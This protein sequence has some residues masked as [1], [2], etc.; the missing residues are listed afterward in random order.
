[1]KKERKRAGLS[2]LTRSS[3]FS[4]SLLPLASKHRERKEGDSSLG[5]G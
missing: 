2:T 1:M 3:N 4:L 5:Y